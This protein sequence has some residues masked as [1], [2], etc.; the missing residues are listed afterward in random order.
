[1]TKHALRLPDFVIG[2]TEK[3]GTTSVF[4]WLA[5]HPEVA[6]SARKETDFFRVEYTGDP[7]FDPARYR[8]HFAHCSPAA[9]IWM[10]ASPGY[11]GEAAQV[12]P[13]MRHLI[14]GARLL[15][16]L[17]DPVERLH[18]S[19]HFHRGR[20]NLP[21]SMCFDDYVRCCLAYDRGECDARRLGLGE[22]Y[23]KVLRFGCYSEGLS[24]YGRE[25][26]EARMK[27]MF[28]ES[29]RAEPRQFMEDLSVFLDIDPTFWRAF[30]F[31]PSNVTFSARHR[32]LHR[33]AVRAN[34]L[35]EPVMR[36]YPVVKRTIVRAYKA[37]NQER[38]GYDPMPAATR[39]LL[40]DY[41]RPSIRALER[42][43][44]EPVPGSW[45]AGPPSRAV[46]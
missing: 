13:R 23:L 36:R 22:W 1:V 25:L 16:I 19:F 40:T 42:W 34:T 21:G 3:A 30:D 33:L 37:L 9:R 15:F 27:V 20:L 2:G 46:A 44:G 6:A 31:R 35:A 5:A 8:A 4:D 17:R 32:S 11:L 12:A 10:E 28:F 43:L 29:L 7:A 24:I 45:Q 39:A 18:S 26:P 14:P 38:E 41:Y